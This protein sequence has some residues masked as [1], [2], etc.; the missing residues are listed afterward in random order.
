MQQLIT[1]RELLYRAVNTAGSRAKL[2]R[3]LTVEGSPTTPRTIYNWQ[4]MP[5]R[6]RFK[7]LLLMCGLVGAKIEDVRPTD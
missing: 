3:Y 2:S 5:R 6:I 1:T 7:A 4:H